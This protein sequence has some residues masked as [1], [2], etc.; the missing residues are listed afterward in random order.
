MEAS[1]Q[2]LIG[3]YDKAIVYALKALELDNNN[4]AI[5]FEI[6]QLY[7][8]TNSFGSAIEYAEKAVKYEDNNEWYNL[9]LAYLYKSS[10][11]HKEA[12]VVFEKILK[13]NPQKVNNYFYLIESYK[14]IGQNLKAVETLE[15][16]EKLIGVNE[17]TSL[18]KRDLYLSLKDKN[19]AL[20]SVQKLIELHPNEPKYFTYLAETYEAIGQPEKA[21]QTYQDV[22]KIDP[23]NGIV[24]FFL[25]QYYLGQKNEEEALTHL[26]Y[27]FKSDEVSIDLKV[28]LLLSLYERNTEKYNKVSY[29]LLDIIVD[30]Y[31]NEAKAYSVYA[32]FLTRDKRIKEAIDKYSKAVELDNTRFPIWNELMLLEIESNNFEKLASDSEKAI[33]IFPSQPSFY[34]FNGLANNQLKN[35]S[36]AIESLNAGKSL[37]LDDKMMMAQF[38][39]MLAEAYHKTKEYE[40]SDKNFDL[41]ISIDSQNPTL[42]NNYSYYLSERGEMLDKAEEMIIKVIAKY[43]TNATFIDTYGWILYKKGNFEDAKKH[44]Q[45]AI[46]LGAKSGEVYEHMGDVNFKLGM[47]NEALEYWNKALNEKDHS[48]LLEQK[49]N[50]KKLYE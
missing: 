46:D 24:H 41:A 38:Y 21:L 18:E 23:D 8:Y 22:L 7:T 12:T 45:K 26:S 25:F 49:I 17:E 19:K 14:Y 27:I 42:L 37:V 48:E 32:D 20:Q 5:L 31:P 2:K 39:Q 28:Q 50:D 6:S 16:L 4:P 29:E 11:L 34:L 43:P 1:K 30:Q 35:Y 9:Q 15:K 33:E 36:K 13:N 44:I 10:G 47:V 3:N 40:K